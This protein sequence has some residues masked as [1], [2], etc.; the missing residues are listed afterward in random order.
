MSELDKLMATEVMRWEVGL[1]DGIE[2]WF[3]RKKFEFQYSCKGWIPSQPEGIGQAM[4]CAEKWIGNSRARRWKFE[5][6]RSEYY[7]SMIEDGFDKGSGPG[8]TKEAEYKG[9]SK[10]SLS[11]AICRAL[12]MAV[13]S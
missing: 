13:K 6:Y 2:G 5:G 9:F 11:Q 3:D 4:Q 7:A 12:V 1:K 10:D 8:S